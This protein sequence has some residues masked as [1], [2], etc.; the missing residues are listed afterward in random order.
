MPFRIEI[1]ISKFPMFLFVL[2]G[3]ITIYHVL[4]QRNFVE[5]AEYTV[6]VVIDISIEEHARGKSY[7]PIIEFVAQDEKVYT[8][9]SNIVNQGYSVGD[10]IGVKYFQ[11]DIRNALIWH[12][13]AVWSRAYFLSLLTVICFITGLGLTI[14]R[15]RT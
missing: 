14:S 12:Y 8:F 15:K 13:D 9:K 4:E 11:D 2:I 10:E 1:K 7:F 3:S 5:N 6:G